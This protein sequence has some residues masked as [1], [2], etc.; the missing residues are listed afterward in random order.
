MIEIPL[1]YILLGGILVF[2]LWCLVGLWAFEN[3]VVER[4]EIVRWSGGYTSRWWFAA[5]TFI[6]GPVVWLYFLGG[7]LWFLLDVLR[8]KV[9]PY[10]WRKQ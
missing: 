7:F 5:M 8:G 3:L 9:F 10:P 4:M 1:D 2:I 6:C